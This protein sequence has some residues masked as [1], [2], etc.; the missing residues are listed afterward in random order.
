MHVDQQSVEES[1][2]IYWYSTDLS[3]GTAARALPRI[4]G[5]IGARLSMFALSRRRNFKRY[6]CTVTMRRILTKIGVEQKGHR[7]TDGLSVRADRVPCE[8]V[9]LDARVPVPV[10]TSSVRMYKLAAQ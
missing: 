5:A 3:F 6:T 4:T 10:M 1:T 9:H 2:A 7:R 8:G